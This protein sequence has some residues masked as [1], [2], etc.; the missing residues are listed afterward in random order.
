MFGEEVLENKREVEPR[1][2]KEGLLVLRTTRGLIGDT[3]EK[4]D[5]QE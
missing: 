5:T 2:F 4:K 3:E 1:S